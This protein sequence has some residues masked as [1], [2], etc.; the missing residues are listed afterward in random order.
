M[1]V[2]AFKNG[3]LHLI[4]LVHF[5]HSISNFSTTCQLRLIRELVDCRRLSV[6]R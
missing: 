6:D 3:R 5:G 1:N 2:N 4:S